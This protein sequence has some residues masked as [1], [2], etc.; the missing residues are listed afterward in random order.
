MV[1]GYSCTNCGYKYDCDVD[2]SGER[3]CPDCGDA[4]TGITGDI[5]GVGDRFEVTYDERLPDGETRRGL[6][7]RVVVPDAESAY[8]RTDEHTLGEITV[9][10]MNRVS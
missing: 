4:V 2:S 7:H 9:T 5:T 6:T 3:I 8:M 1:V 10:K